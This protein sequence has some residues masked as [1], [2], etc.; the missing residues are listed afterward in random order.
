MRNRSELHRNYNRSSELA[1]GRRGFGVR[2][3]GGV[4]WVRQLGGVVWVLRL[5]G[6]GFQAGPSVSVRTARARGLMS[7]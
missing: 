7:H 4:V 5:D 3:L 2:Q 6:V 1:A